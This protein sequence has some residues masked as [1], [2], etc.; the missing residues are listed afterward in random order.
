MKKIICFIWILLLGVSC[1]KDNGNYSYDKVNTITSKGLQPSYS[2]IRFE[3]LKIRCPKLSFKYD[4]IK[5]LSYRWKIDYKVVSEERDLDT[6]VD[7]ELGNKDASLTVIDNSTKYEYYFEFK[8][9]VGTNFSHGLYFLVEMPDGSASLSF[10]N[11]DR[12]SDLLFAD[13]IY[14]KT[15]PEMAPLGTKP[16]QLVKPGSGKLLYIVCNGGGDDSKISRIDLNTIILNQ[17]LNKESVR[18]GDGSEVFEPDYMS[19]F[20]RDALISSKGKLFTYNFVG[21]NALYRPAKGDYNIAPHVFLDYM[22]G[23]YFAVGF[24]VVKEKLVLFTPDGDNYAYD[25][26]AF[27]EPTDGTLLNG[28]ELIASGQTA[29]NPYGAMGNAMDWSL[30]FYNRLTKEL[31]FYKNTI[32]VDINWATFGYDAIFVALEKTTLVAE[33]ADE[34]SK[35]KFSPKTK[36]WYFSKGAVLYKMHHNEKEPRAIWTSTTGDITSLAINSNIPKAHPDILLDEM[37]LFVTTYDGTSTNER[38][39]SLYVINT[40]TENQIESYPNS[41]YKCVST[42]YSNI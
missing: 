10:A 23:P 6:I 13:N 9:N 28:L 31:F 38:K 15:N 8:V 29:M 19:D 26:H 12:K 42:V 33:K 14:S 7:A 21:A 41:L 2:A 1:A 30:V 3:P 36:Y 4:D 17:I 35:I 22:Y 20:Y 32:A 16:I 39:G 5:D 37:H 27:Y 11:R 25:K 18:G 24:D 40:S 34:N